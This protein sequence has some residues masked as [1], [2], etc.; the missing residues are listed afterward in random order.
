MALGVG[1]FCGLRI[2]KPA[3]LSAAQQYID[4]HRMFDYRLISTLGFTSED[5]AYFAALHGVKAAE[6]AVYADVLCAGTDGGNRALRVHSITENVNQLSLTA[7]RMPENDREAVVDARYMD[8]SAIGTQFTLSPDNTQD[9][10][11]QFRYSSYTI[12]GLA[13]SVYYLNYERGNTSLGSGSISG[14]VYIPYGGFNLDYYSEIFVDL[15]TVGSIYSD[16]YNACLDDFEAMIER[17]CEKRS[18][19]RYRSL[20]EEA[21]QEIDD[22]QSELDE[23]YDEFTTEKSD[24]PAAAQGCACRIGGCRA[25]DRRWRARAGPK[26]E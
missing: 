25:A 24:A 17:E 3:M 7:G 11:D 18:D 8:A 4:E 1:F 6:G 12:V 9:T 15:D 16:E 19:L 20:V 14:F 26:L 10:L 13:N 2:C 22:A 21:Q 5:P 23:K